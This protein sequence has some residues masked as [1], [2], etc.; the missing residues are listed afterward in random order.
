M[1]T[2]IS[3]HLQ[4]VHRCPV[5][6]HLCPSISVTLLVSLTFTMSLT[7]DE[8]NET[9]ETGLVGIENHTHFI[10]EPVSLIGG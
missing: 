8:S 10:Y 7:H 5:M 4:I 6:G 1:P 9:N 3:G 2:G